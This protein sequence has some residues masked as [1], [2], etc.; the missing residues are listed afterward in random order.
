MRHL[1]KLMFGASCQMPNSF[2][3]G[4][5]QTSLQLPDV[6]LPPFLEMM[7][8]SPLL[9]MSRIESSGCEWPELS[10]GTESSR[11]ESHLRSHSASR[12]SL[13]IVMHVHQL[14]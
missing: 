2:A 4:D 1:E 8:V 5:L 7:A 9:N 13:A 6:S 10:P 3:A 11:A 12:A 14:I